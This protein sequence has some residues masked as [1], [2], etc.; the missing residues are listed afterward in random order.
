[1]KPE[2]AIFEQPDPETEA[3]ADAL[4]EADIVA[5]RAVDHAD[6]AAWLAT[7]GTK[8]EVPAPPQWLE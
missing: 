1:M 7:W 8:D 6:V 3:A 5:G 4:A 2:K